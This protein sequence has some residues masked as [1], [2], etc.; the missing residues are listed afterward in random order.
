MTAGRERGAGLRHDPARSEQR[1]QLREHGV[2]FAHEAGREAAPDR[3]AGTLQHPLPRHVVGPLF[4]T[5]EA[6]AVA[7]DRE[8]FWSVLHDGVLLERGMPQY[9]MLDRDQAMKIYAYIRHEARNVKAAPAK[10]VQ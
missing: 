2:A 6:V 8:A 10:R 3:P 7:F 5:M 1:D 9:A 4:G